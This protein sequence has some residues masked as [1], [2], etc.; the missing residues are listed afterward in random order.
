[1]PPFTQR[2]H[3]CADSLVRL[4]RS[5]FK[6]I[7]DH[8]QEHRI[9]LVDALM[10]GFALFSLKSP[11]LLAFDTERR[12][13]AFNLS[14]LFGLQSIPCDTQMRTILD[15]VNPRHLRPAFASVFRACQRGKVLESFVFWQ[16]HYLI[17][18]DGTCYF[19]SEKV[20]CPHCLE[21]R[22]RNGIVSYYHQM[23]GLAIVHPDCKI[24]LPLCPEP[25][26][27][28]DG[29]NKNDGETSATRRALQHF[30]R[31]HPHLKA[32]FV[33]DALSAN[34][35]HVE[36][37]R[38]HNI[39]FILSVKP[40]KQTSLFEDLR[41]ADE[42][43][44]TCVLTLQDPDGTLHHFRWLK[45]L[46][47]NKGNPDLRV[48]LLDYW[49][50]PPRDAGKNAQQHHF[51]WI[52]DLDF[53]DRS[54]YRLMRGGRGRWR[55]EN[56]IFNTLK[57]QGYQFEHNFGHGDNQLSVVFALL[58]MLAFLVDQVQQACDSLFQATL[59]KIGSKC[60]L[61]ERIRSLFFCFHFESF[62]TLY[63]A[64]LNF[65]PGTLPLPV[66]NTS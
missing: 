9:S 54:V 45:D 10:S 48:A 62:R 1:M 31:E 46:P 11:S 2:T 61:W 65:E 50:I 28:Q 4:L 17:V 55:V 24:V 49:E 47:L 40:G 52:T 37:L 33:E 14:A 43:N 20:H 63:E 42:E 23:L 57:N 51:T 18:S 5:E 27:R 26:V 39:R 15:D 44:R 58:L 66:P 36:D 3:L 34:A 16:N 30:R 8:R 25:I 60:R 35:P 7:P 53:D 22:S 41:Q 59:D 56:E 6:K 29:S 12:H 13:N 64:L 19:A 38:R 21:K 32:I